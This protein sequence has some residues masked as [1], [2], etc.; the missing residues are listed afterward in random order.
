MGVSECE[1]LFPSIVSHQP[2]LMRLPGEPKYEQEFIDPYN[3]CTVNRKIPHLKGKLCVGCFED[4]L[5]LADEFTKEIFFLHRTLDPKLKVHLPSLCVEYFKCLRGCVVSSSPLSRECLVT[6]VGNGEFL[7]GENIILYC[8]PKRDARW[9]KLSLSIHS[10]A[11]HEFTGQ[12]V[13]FKGKIYALHGIPIA[14]RVVVINEDSLLKGHCTWTVVLLPITNHCKHHLVVSCDDM[15][16]V[17]VTDRFQRQGF[18]ASCIVHRVEISY[19][20]WKRVESIGG[21]AFFLGRMQSSALPPSQEGAEC[22][23]IYIAN[24]YFKKGIYKICLQDQTVSLSF[25]MKWPER[26]SQL[27]WLMPIR[28]HHSWRRKHEIFSFTH[29]IGTDKSDTTHVQEEEKKEEKCKVDISRQ[30]ADMPIELV[31]LLLP[32]LYL[33]DCLRL[34]SVCKAWNTL[35]NLIQD[36]KVYPWFL[37]TT[38]DK[39]CLWNLFDPVYRKECSIDMKWLG[40]SQDISFQFSKDGWVLVLKEDKYLF[41]INPFTR[42]CIGLPEKDRRKSFAMSFSSSPTNLDC[43]VLVISYV[44][45]HLLEISTWRPGEDEWDNIYFNY[46]YN[47]LVPFNP[48]FI[49]GEFYCFCRKGK[50][51]V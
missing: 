48:V 21:C 3:H 33:I 6:F 2:R 25:L 32:R 30:W 49:G 43:I 51:L 14:Y 1:D 41:L 26:R 24:T 42:E 28:V 4:W 38:N 9:T 46:L 40:F 22:D 17:S 36:A 35:A 29:P 5:L 10:E 34:P 7:R 27:F 13:R 50:L 16:L 37:R 20:T 19:H 47:F 45:R 15:F 11:F 23:C 39:S 44:G 12:V 31:E 8:R 18:P